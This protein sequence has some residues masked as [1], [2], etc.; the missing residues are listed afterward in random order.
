VYQRY[1]LLFVFTAQAVGLAIAAMAEGAPLAAPE[2]YP[3]V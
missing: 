2:N 1:A 3:A